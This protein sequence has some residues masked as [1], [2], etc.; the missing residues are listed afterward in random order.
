[1]TTLTT[2]HGVRIRQASAIL[3]TLLA[4]ED[5]RFILV[6]AAGELDASLRE[7]HT[8]RLAGVRLN[9]RMLRDDPNLLRATDTM[10]LPV[11]ISG[12]IELIMTP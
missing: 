5:V 3:R 9:L 2:T 8:G 4:P 10:L 12:V 7:G 11:A 6:I 1:M